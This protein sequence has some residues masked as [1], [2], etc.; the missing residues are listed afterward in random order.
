[1]GSYREGCRKPNA[2]V[3]WYPDYARINISMIPLVVLSSYYLTVIR[4]LLKLQNLFSLF[5]ATWRGKLST[6]YYLVYC[7]INS[8]H[9]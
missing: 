9:P 3:S 4:W 6:W 8:V 2:S 1:M 7:L 5:M